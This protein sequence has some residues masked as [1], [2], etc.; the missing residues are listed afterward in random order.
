MKFRTF[1]RSKSVGWIYALSFSGGGGYVKVA[2]VL[3][4][5]REFVIT[6]GKGDD[7]DWDECE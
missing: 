5:Q 3:L 2:S 4:G 7:F 1:S 6:F